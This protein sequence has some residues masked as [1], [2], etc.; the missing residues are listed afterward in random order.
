MIGVLMKAGARPDPR[1][2]GVAVA[3]AKAPTVEALLKNGGNPNASGPPHP[4]MRPAEFR[5]LLVIATQSGDPAVV[6]VLLAAGARPDARDRLGWTPLRWAHEARTK[7]FPGAVEIFALLDSAGARDTAGLRANDLIDAVTRN[8]LEG[9]RAA[10]AVGADPNARD[11]RGVSALIH[12]AARRQGQIA[13]ALIAAGADVNA[14]GVYSPTALVAA[15]DTGDI[16]M[17]RTLLA[18]GARRDLMDSRGIAPLMSAARKS[19]A[20]MSILLLADSTVQVPNPAIQSAVARGDSALVAMF[21]A[22]SKP[23][24]EA[25]RWLMYTAA[26]GCGSK[27]NGPVIRLLL[28][29]GFH[30]DGW[31]WGPTLVPA[32]GKCSPDVVQLL[33]QRGADV[34]RKHY[35]GMT[36]LM[37]AA[38]EG[39]LENVRVLLAAGAKVNVDDGGGLT[40]LSYAR[41]PEIRQAL[42]KVGA[43]GDT[44]SRQSRHSAI[45][46]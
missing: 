13:K 46:Y 19:N 39:R 40:A 37:V 5:P 6:R 45:A 12:A 32:A 42:I 1:M 33:I 9:V 4:G 34:N 20:E 24:E 18:A 44:T 26:R 41:K 31:Q 16:E 30:A 27:D 38:Y 3:R 28:D 35:N 15:I 22:R 2:L 7:K 17:M 25:R 36:P 23:S 21:L 29:H 11:V 43:R 10:L 14:T 8:D